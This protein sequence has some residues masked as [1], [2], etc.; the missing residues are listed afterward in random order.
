MLVKTIYEKSDNEGFVGATVLNAKKGAYMD[1]IVT[2]LDFASL[3]PTIMRA[4]NLCYN[5]IVCDSKYANIP[6]ITY[7][8]IEWIIDGEK[9]Q[10]SFAQ[11]YQ[12]V[13]PKLLENLAI[14]RK[15]AKKDMANA[16]K[17]GDSFMKSVYNGKQLAFKV[18]MNSIYGFC[19]AQM[20]PCPDISASVTT[21]GRNMIEKTKMLVE[22]W[23][24]GSEVIYGDTDSVMTIFNT[25]DL[26]G[27]DALKESFRLGKEAA[28][29]I[30]DTFKKPI[31]LEFE[32]CYYPYLL[33]S[34]KRYAGLMYTNPE[35]PDYIDAK[36]IQLVRRDNCE[37]VRVVSQQV[38]NK[39]MYDKDVK[40]AIDIVQE[41]AA[42]LLKGEIPVDSL[43]VS[44]SLR[45]SY[46]SQ[47]T[48]FKLKNGEI[49][50]EKYL[51]ENNK[52]INLQNDVKEKIKGK[53][54][55][56][57]HFTVAEKI[58]QRMPG[59]KPKCGERVPYVFIET[60]NPKDQQFKKAEDPEYVKKNG[61]RIDVKY[62][63]E[64][65]LTSPMQS[66]FELFM[67]DPKEELFETVWKDPDVKK[68]LNDPQIQKE[69][70]MK[71]REMSKELNIKNGQREISSF[72]TAKEQK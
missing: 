68:A 71:E 53:D 34:K 32:K 36:G 58:E 61:L 60:Y 9:K 19:A 55:N 26:K 43:V 62:Y 59:T 2:G 25:G 57:P 16:E 42:K 10:C 70:K 49:V 27:D 13:L 17:N 15:I 52:L 31:E 6:G 3:Y 72:F 12:G 29:R 33:F 14:N 66:L 21:I 4:H 35:T 28:D 24:P 69:R 63:L 64:H 50:D 30:S 1:K 18:S 7:E 56:L 67:K 44:K 22:K 65:A 45:K 11:D 48:K 39:I 38:L 20:L 5:T 46:A 51:K 47:K 37:L 54:P 40:G 23:Y 41:T 8:T